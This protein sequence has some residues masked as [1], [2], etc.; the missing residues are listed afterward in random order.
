MRGRPVT[1]AQEQEHYETIQDERKAWVAATALINLSDEPNIDM[2]SDEEAAIVDEAEDDE[3]DAIHP[4]I[5]TVDEHGWDSSLTDFTIPPFA[6]DVG[7]TTDIDRPLPLLQLFLTPRLMRRIAAATTSYARSKGAASDWSTDSSELYR[8]IAVHIAMGIQPCP[9]T[10]MYWCAGWSNDF[11]WN[12]M[13]RNRYWELIRY[14]HVVDPSVPYNSTTPLVKV[15]PLISDLQSSFQMY[16]QPA[17]DICIDEAM[18]PYKGRSRLKQYIPSKPHKY[19]YKVWCLASQGYVHRFEVYEGKEEK[20]SEEGSLHQVVMRLVQPYRNKHHI[21]FVDNHFT[22]PRLFDA[23]LSIGVH[24]CGTVQPKRR[25]FP[26]SLVSA[27]ALL[28]RGGCT[29]KQRGQLVATAYQ[30]RQTV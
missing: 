6:F 9:M 23:L 26:R 10:A 17:R 13:A 27:A 7:P 28:S 30:D 11:I 1:L 22:S 25:E 12:T 15:Q 5:V 19:G 29:H 20:T 16:Y 18:I 2:S 8:L 4:P 24:A 21:L 3:E 14:F